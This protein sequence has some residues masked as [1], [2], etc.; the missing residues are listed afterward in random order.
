MT[1]L[2]WLQRLWLCGD[3]ARRPGVLGMGRCVRTEPGGNAIRFL[4][5]WSTGA[6]AEGAD[7]EATGR[8]VAAAAKLDLVANVFRDGV[9]GGLVMTRLQVR[10]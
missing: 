3:A 10:A 9:H 6:A 1:R 7:E 4:L 2:S 8:L 5:H